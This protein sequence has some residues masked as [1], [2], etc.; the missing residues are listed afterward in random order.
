MNRDLVLMGDL[1]QAI[2]NHFGGMVGG[3][4]WDTVI[5]VMAR[6]ISDGTIPLEAA[7]RL[8]LALTRTR[9]MGPDECP[10]CPGMRW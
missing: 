5:E 10:V 1:R 6:A 4:Y 3:I 8:D 2:E 9:E 7:A